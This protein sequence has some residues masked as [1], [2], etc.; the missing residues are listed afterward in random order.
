MAIKTTRSVSSFGVHQNESKGSVQF[1]RGC[2]RIVFAIEN[3]AAESNHT[4][5]LSPLQR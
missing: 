5:A 4:N 2:N 3:R 1:K